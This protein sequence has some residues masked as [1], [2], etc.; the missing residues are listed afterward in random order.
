M[1]EIFGLETGKYDWSS[2]QP[3]MSRCLIFYHGEKSTRKILWVKHNIIF[4]FEWL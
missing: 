4:H 2:A 1:G 3:K